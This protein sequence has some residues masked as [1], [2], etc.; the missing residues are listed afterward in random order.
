M[1][2][3]VGA[4]IRWAFTGPLVVWTNASDIYN[5]RIK[6]NV[7]WIHPVPLCIEYMFLSLDRQQYEYDQGHS[8]GYIHIITLVPWSDVSAAQ[9]TA[10]SHET[11]SNTY[12]PSCISEMYF[13]IVITY[14]P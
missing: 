11:K 2:L 4:D 12:K 9:G 1:Y 6:I 10:G 14:V 5:G 8:Y 7:L 13:F 3:V